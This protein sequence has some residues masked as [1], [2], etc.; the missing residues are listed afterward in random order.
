MILRSRNQPAEFRNGGK[1]EILNAC[2]R[3]GHNC[4]W[5]EGNDVLVPAGQRGASR[6]RMKHIRGRN[7]VRQLELADR[8]IGAVVVDET[9]EHHLLLLGGKR[10]DAG[11][12]RSGVD[13]LGSDL[14]R[15][16][17]IEVF[18]LL[19]LRREREENAGEQGGSNADA[20]AGREEASTIEGHWHGVLWVG[21]AFS[22]TI[23]EHG[24]GIVSVTSSAGLERWPRAANA[25]AKCSCLRCMRIRTP[26]HR[27]GARRRG[28]RSPL[29][30]R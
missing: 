19:R 16:G 2:W 28:S 29:C 20:A 21:S 18:R 12:Y 26:I 7:R 15:L 17:L 14:W 22:T 4:D 27:A 23:E 3:I 13:H 5:D 10:T 11:Q 1:S 30:R 8:F 9:V 25:T 6:Q 24:A